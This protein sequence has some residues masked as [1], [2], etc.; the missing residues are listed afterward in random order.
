[1]RRAGPRKSRSRKIYEKV[2]RDLR[3]RQEV[4]SSRDQLVEQVESTISNIK[5][6]LSDLDD[7]T[8]SCEQYLQ[9]LKTPAVDLHRE[10]QTEEFRRNSTEF[11]RR[12]SQPDLPSL[13]RSRIALFEAQSTGDLREEQLRPPGILNLHKNMAYNQ[14]LNFLDKEAETS[15]EEGSTTSEQRAT[16][17]S[18]ETWS[19]VAQ[20]TKGGADQSADDHLSALAKNIDQEAVQQ[21]ITGSS[22]MPNQLQ[23][24]ENYVMGEESP[25]TSRWQKFCLRI[26]TA[27]SHH[28]KKHAETVKALQKEPGIPH[29]RALQ[30]RYSTFH[31]RYKLYEQEYN[32]ITAEDDV[33]KMNIVFASLQD[34]LDETVGV[35]MVIEDMLA[36]LQPPKAKAATGLEVKDLT[37]IF[38][39]GNAKPVDLPT[40]NGKKIADYNAFKKKF[41]YVIQ[42]TITPKELWATQLEDSL[43]DNAK[44]YIGS[45]GSWYGKYEELW[46]AL[47][48]KYA[49]R[50]N[51]ATNTINSFFFKPDPEDGQESVLNWTYQMLDDLKAVEELGLTIGEVGIN[52]IIQRLPKEYAR[53]VRTGL[54]T[55]HAGKKAKA[56]FTAKEFR[57]VVN[58][59]IAIKHEPQSS[60]APRSTLSLQTIPTPIGASAPL[61][62]A[63][64]GQPGTG[65]YTGGGTRFRSRA[66]RGRGRGGRSGSNTNKEA[67]GCEMCDQITHYSRHCKRFKSPKERRTRLKTIHKCTVCA[68]REHPNKPCSTNLINMICH[69]D[70]NKGGNKVHRYWACGGKDDPHPGMPE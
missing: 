59:T 33:D 35:L 31:Q 56:A 14:D 12:L 68:Q 46:E 25:L 20:K 4:P 55:T 66:G 34:A 48:D 36:K 62:A 27:L 19:E 44:D 41:Q 57:A 64:T 49:N 5:T 43:T 2:E 67:I 11:S 3:S 32:E 7:S 47:D 26:A 53:E 40:F 29:L 18:K 45:K 58:D 70:C 37:S 13:V 24:Q 28:A 52:L 54:R 6:A 23:A 39:F 17:T 30:E 10:L 51:I 1:M 9:E 38:K 65:F 69:K 16:K 22:R 60:S 63:P 42:H 8:N 15:G 61:S 50:W 21:G